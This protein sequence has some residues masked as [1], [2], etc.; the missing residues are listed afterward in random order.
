M[1]DVTKKSIVNSA[2]KVR[3]QMTSVNIGGIDVFG[4]DANPNEMKAYL[5]KVNKKLLKS[6]DTVYYGTVEFL[7]KENK[8]GLY[9]DGC[10]YLSNKKPDEIIKTIFHELS[11]SLEARV[12]DEVETRS[13][14]VD[15]FTKKRLEYFKRLY[16]SG[17]TK[18][19]REDFMQIT[20]DPVL[21]QVLATIDENDNKM[22]AIGV[23]PTVYSATSIEE[24]VAGGFEVYY[25]GNKFN[26]GKLCPN[27]YGFIKEVEGLLT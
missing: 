23:F 22:A 2:R 19:K 20:F 27:L 14:L 13:E 25:A 12:R 4:I 1:D 7:E 15:E 3:N 21:D 26:L 5:S 16:D 11:H 8:T 10:L 6:I 24:Y 18:L 17:Y 9:R